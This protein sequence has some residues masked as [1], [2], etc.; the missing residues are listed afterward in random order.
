[1][2]LFVHLTA[3]APDQEP[4][5]F[6]QPVE[7]TFVE[8]DRGLGRPHQVRV[9]L[10]SEAIEASA[11]G[12]LVDWIAGHLIH[13]DLVFF[14]VHD[15]GG[16]ALTHP[17]R[18]ERSSS[19]DGLELVGVV[20]AEQA[21]D[22]D[23]HAPR[24][25]VHPVATVGALFAVVGHL[26]TPS[27]KVDSAFSGISL[28]GKKK[29]NP[30]LE[31][32]A[33]RLDSLK[34]LKGFAKDLGKGAGAA[35]PGGF[36]PD[37]LLGS[38][39]QGLKERLAE[40][41]LKV[42]L[43]KGFN[44]G[45]KAPKKLPKSA[46]DVKGMLSLGKD[47]P[48][49]PPPH[50]VQAGI[51]DRQLL[52]RVLGALSRDL[53][54]LPR[55]VVT[56][57]H[58]PP[59][60]DQQGARADGRRITFAR[61]ADFRKHDASIPIVS[62][63]ERPGLTADAWE[64][65]SLDCE[66]V[67]GAAYSRHRPAAIRR[68]ISHFGVE[69]WRDWADR[70]LPWSYEEGDA[71]IIWR[72]VDKLQP[73]GDGTGTEWTSEHHVLP[74]DAYVPAAQRVEAFEPGLAIGTVSASSPSSASLTVTLDRFTEQQSVTCL[75]GTPFSGIDGKT[76]I[77]LVPATGQRVVVAWSGHLGD[78]PVATVDVRHKAPARP[79]P[80]V[81]LSRT[82]EAKLV[83]VD[84]EEVGTVTV[85]SNLEG[86]LEKTVRLSVKEDA[87]LRVKKRT[88]LQV[89]GETR[90]DLKKGADVDIEKD[91]DLRVDGRAVVSAAKGARAA[92]NKELELVGGGL[93]AALKN[94]A[95]DVG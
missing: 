87:D 71:P 6:E 33:P 52:D 92:S 61:G 75:N 21:A 42:D 79:A 46:G 16:E 93:T 84:I 44:L 12:V 7:V 31:V 50:V 36:S 83:A 25:R 90:V 54:E 35:G 91:L 86:R 53:E 17:A 85:K 41:K 20:T 38:A 82:L 66:G 43:P 40:S 30:P 9:R 11:L 60:V 13:G 80:S 81:D 37:Q 64:L 27:D 70:D 29:T 78:L 57:A 74:D 94:G 56:G 73:A 14:E 26:A 4:D 45:I 69:T 22:A 88:G 58:E 67:P 65:C 51:S 8:V 19:S 18:L 1:M 39:S 24:W 23:E 72:T 59:P 34:N 3:L 76:G 49:L 48:P 95:M 47:D 89:G 28:A 32:F 68:V 55:L 62:P 15:G 2:A 10:E 63:D 5:S 77:N